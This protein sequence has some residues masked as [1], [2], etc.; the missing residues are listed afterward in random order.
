MVGLSMLK[1]LRTKALVFFLS[2]L[3][4][5]AFFYLA[6]NN[7]FGMRT[8]LY[9]DT[10]IHELSTIQKGEVI[11]RGAEEK[12]LVTLSGRVGML[13]R[14]VEVAVVNNEKFSI[15]P[16]EWLNLDNDP[17]GTFF[18]GGILIPSGLSTIFLKS[19]RNNSPSPRTSNA[20]ELS[21][22]EIFIVAGQS[23]AGG[24][25]N[26]LFIP[27]SNFVH[28]GQ[29]QEDGSLIWKNGAD[30]QIMGG[31]GSVWPLVGD[32]LF[33][34]LNVP[35]GFINV[36]AGATSIIEWQPDHI[37][38]QQLVKAVKSIK[39]HGHRAIL[40]HQG[41]SDHWISAGEYYHLLS[42]L[43]QK[44][45]EE[46]KLPIP[47]MVAQA[48]YKDDMISEAVR[49]GQR[50]SWEMPRVFEGPDTDG[51]QSIYRHDNVHFN[52]EGTRAAAALWTEKIY[53]A[54]FKH[55]EPI[56]ETAEAKAY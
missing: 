33:L 44:V 45:E 39:P 3:L 21:V 25:S 6:F 1:V 29:F 28:T 24:S 38:F 55:Q 8:T 48:S 37:H 56:E 50:R 26:T 42:N 52:E 19:N 9:L 47:W 35:I 23:N 18:K 34:K 51:L 41:E 31:G 22:G 49:E 43:I 30:P 10:K 27:R 13:A 16:K 7:T 36:A 11:Q 54:F 15:H 32:Q 5:S 12:I 53:Q 4:I 20:F 40:W 14:Q 2:V 17:Y 46:T